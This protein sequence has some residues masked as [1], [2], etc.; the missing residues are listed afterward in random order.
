M[1]VSYRDKA[2]LDICSIVDQLPP[3]TSIG[4]YRAEFRKNGP[5]DVY[6]AEFRI[7]H[8]EARKRIKQI[9]E[10]RAKKNKL[11]TLF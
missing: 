6:S 10:L 4:E 5:Q 2:I 11:T 1:A 3:E 8:Q 9:Y 7:F